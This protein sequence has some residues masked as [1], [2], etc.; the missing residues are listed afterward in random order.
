MPL[1]LDLRPHMTQ[2]WALCTNSP[3]TEAGG[4]ATEHTGREDLLMEDTGSIPPI[5][6]L[7]ER[8]MHRCSET[9]EE[10]EI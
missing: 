4:L 6:T 7:M 1:V 5:R 10:R 9:V 8:E 3:L 2:D